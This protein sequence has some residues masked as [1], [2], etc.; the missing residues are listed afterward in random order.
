MNALII[1]SSLLD[2]INYF[3]SLGG[4]DVNELAVVMERFKRHGI[5]S[6]LDLS[7]EADMDSNPSMSLRE[8]LEACRNVSEM[9]KE[10]IDIASLQPNSF[11]A[12]KITALIP[13]PLLLK[14][15]HS[16]KFLEEHFSK[17]SNNGL[18]GVLNWNEFSHI[19]T[20]LPNGKSLDIS[21]IKQLFHHADM[22]KKTG[23]IDWIDFTETIN[24]W[25]PIARHVLSQPTDDPSPGNTF[26]SKED[27]HNLDILKNRILEL[28]VYAKE[29][30]VGL[31][32]DAEQTYF[33]PAVDSIALQL[34]KTINHSFSGTF[35]ERPL[36]YNTYQL[37]LID[38]LQRLKFD[39]E[40]AER[41]DYTFGLKVV[42]GNRCIT[43]FS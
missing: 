37:Y 42:R 39:V 33:Q 12:I 30:K 26:L 19:L 6:I 41:Y 32:V 4:E 1:V 15:T 8:S 40:R 25:N 17:Y 22:K 10:S 21:T 13:P 16:L 7:I 28:G 38:S 35:T 43:N 5:G 31:T 36:I 23:R 14:M 29:K 20:Q 18:N 2:Y 34:C 11:I 24:F 27:L 3:Y 9:M